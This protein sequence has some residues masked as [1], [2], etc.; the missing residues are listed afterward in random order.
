MVFI[1]GDRIAYPFGVDE[2]YVGKVTMVREQT[3]HILFDDG[4]RLSFPK[5]SRKLLKIKL[6]GVRKT[7]LTKDQIEKLLPTFVK[8]P[9]TVDNRR[10]K[11]TLVGPNDNDQYTP[12]TSNDAKIFKKINPKLWVYEDDYEDF[13]KT[14][15]KFGI[16]V[17]LER[18]K[19]VTEF[20][21]LDLMINKLLRDHWDKKYEI[22]DENRPELRSHYI[23]HKANAIEVELS[24]LGSWD[25]TYKGLNTLQK[26]LINMAR[27]HIEKELILLM[28]AH[29]YNFSKV[30][31][32]GVMFGTD[33]VI[34][35]GY[36][37]VQ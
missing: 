5:K 19:R 1:K 3:V 14:A 11:L 35:I 21:N 6:N 18:T 33:T 36:K 12:A 32:P 29:G 26:T 31:T 7:H 25:S 30:L 34:S 16:D 27:V 28:E 37:F 20:V 23:I 13:L 24:L 8:Q 10:P 22:D 9:K 17:V 15:E 2:Y 4:E